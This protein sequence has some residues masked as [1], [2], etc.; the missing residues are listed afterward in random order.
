MQGILL[1]LID[2]QKSGLGQHVDIALFEAML[3]V[4]RLPMSVLLAT[5]VTPTRVGNDHLEHRAVRA[6]ARQGRADHRGGRE[7]AA[8]GRG[9]ATRSSGRNCAT[10]R[11]SRPTPT[12]SRTAPALKQAIEAGLPALHGRGADRAASGAQ[13]AVRPRAVDRARRSRIRRSPRATSSSRS[14]IRS[15]ARSRP[16]RRSSGCRA[17]RREVRLPPPALGEHTAEVLAALKSRV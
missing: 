4:M 1:A 16:S 12:A 14:S 10:I 7:S 15:S 17:R 5:G 11:G 13:R 8:V 2:R 3:S 6:A 9:S